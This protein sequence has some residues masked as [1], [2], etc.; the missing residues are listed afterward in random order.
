MA[1]SQLQLVASL[2]RYRD[3][4]DAALPPI[5][6]LRE[7]EPDVEPQIDAF[8]LQLGERV[9]GLQ[10]AEAQG[11]RQELRAR[12]LELAAESQALGF[13]PLARAAAHVL[14]CCAELDPAALHKAVEALTEV[15]QRV[16]RGHR[17]A[18]G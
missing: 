15:A 10:D 3:M 18:A 11:A 13:P 12:S 5:R 1:L 16:R 9:D 4:A 6:S 14:A 2:R 8:V 17:S 7:H